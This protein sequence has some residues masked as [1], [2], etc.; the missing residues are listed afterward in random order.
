MLKHFLESN[1]R[2]F[3]A[4][5]KSVGWMYSKEIKAEI[6]QGH[7]G[8]VEYPERWSL[9]LRRKLDPKAPRLWYGQMR[10]AIGYEY[11]DGKVN[12]GWTS[13]TASRYG[14]LQ[15]QGFKK[16]VTQ[17]MRNYFRSVGINLGSSIQQLNIPARPIYEPMAT[18]MSPKIAPYVEEKLTSYI[19]GNI[20]FGK[21]NRRVYKVY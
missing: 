21:K 7:A 17:K 2:Y 13:A 8:N 15:E 12:I 11:V 20:A 9:E 16:A 6:K 10:K 1:P 3:R 14:D 19:R 4:L 5:G 18:E